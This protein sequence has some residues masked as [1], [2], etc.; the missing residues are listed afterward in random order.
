M[1][2]GLK[3]GETEGADGRQ[4]TGKRNSSDNA[5][6]SANGAHFKATRNT[7]SGLEG[8][9]MD[10]VYQ[11]LVH[12]PERTFYNFCRTY[13]SARSSG[14]L[15]PSSVAAQQMQFPSSYSLRDCV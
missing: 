2:I 14:P 7:P 5:A 4:Q 8:T 13:V 10:W 6:E 9:V 15:L 1:F 12:F 11:V 3:E